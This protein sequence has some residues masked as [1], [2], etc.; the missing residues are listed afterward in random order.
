MSSKS[1]TSAQQQ[2]SYCKDEMNLAEFPLCVIGTRPPKG[3]KTL[4]FEDSIEHPKTGE[5]V[6]RKLTVT[7]SDLLGLPTSI[8][9][10]V[11]M[12]CLKLTMDR[13]KASQKVP[14]TAYQ[15]LEE[16]RWSRDG[17][18]YR[19]LTESLDRWTGVMVL[20]NNAFWHKGKQRVVKDTFGLIDRWKLVDEQNAQREA[21][22]WFVWG[23]LI[24][25]SIES[26]YLRKLDYNLW[27]SLDSPVAKRLYRLLGKRFYKRREISFPLATLAHDKVGISRNQHTGQVKKSLEKGHSELER[28]G[29]CQC[30]FVRRG[31][32]NWEVVYTDLTKRLPKPEQSHQEQ[33]FRAELLDR[34]LK[35]A[36]ELLRKQKSRSRIQEAIKNYDDRKHQGEELSPNWLAANILHETGYSFRKDYRSHSAKA[37]E[38]AAAQQ[39]A[40]QEQRKAEQF[41]AEVACHNKKLRDE[42]AAYLESLPDDATRETF[43]ERALEAIPMYRQLL[44]ESQRQQNPQRASRHRQDVMFL[45]WKQ[46]YA[47]SE[48]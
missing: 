37:A 24:W 45:Y 20:S 9:E 28:K 27:K 43:L 38:K 10:E 47:N 23:D 40:K 22:G 48:I 1:P 33:L 25:E 7:G 11:L 18:G 19:R 36:D 31:P 17:R 3:V 42:F 34:G 21:N 46:L 13:R 14:F 15:F 35:N 32:G 26:G 6:V 8:D 16:L 4:V 44:N 41:Q 12:G 30:R 2:P 5:P 29:F 39:R